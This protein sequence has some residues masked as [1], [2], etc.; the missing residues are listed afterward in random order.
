[1]GAARSALLWASQN[2][3]LAKRVPRLGF[4]RRAL[5]RFM[6]GEELGAALA[7]AEHLA[8]H[9]I[10]TTFTHLGENVTDRAQADEVVSHYQGVLERVHELELDTEI[11][12]KLTHLGLDLDAGRAGEHLE[13]LVERAGELGNWVWVDMESSEYVDRTLDTYRRARAR[14][15]NVGVCLQAYLHRTPDDIAELL[16]HQPG[17]RLVKGAYREP[18][19][20]ALTRRRDVDE[21]FLELAAVLLH[22]AAAG[23]ARVAMA[24]HDVDLLDRVAIVGRGIGLARDAYEIQMLYGIR[25]PDQY[26]L[27]EEGYAMRNLVAYGT[28]WYPWYVR[29]LAERPGNLWFVVR[30]M[31]VRP[32]AAG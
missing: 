28:A 11:S 16:P 31:A 6:P 15:P 8:T 18:A 12:V 29:R 25:M 13:T 17:I 5:S 22:H 9:G 3:W 2:Q 7:A 4:V 23:E 24:T 19:S 26:R 10:V 20:L 14:F 21:R 1:M 32:R 30:S 27:A